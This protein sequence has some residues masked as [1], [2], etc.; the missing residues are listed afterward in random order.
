VSRSL[1]AG[2]AAAA[3]TLAAAAAAVAPAHAITNGN[4][5]DGGH[6][7]VGL[8]VAQDGDG[9]PLWRCSGTLVSGTVFVT[10]GHCT[11]DEQGG[12][13]ENVEVWFGQGP[14]SPSTA[15]REGQGDLLCQDDDGNRYDGYPCSGD[16]SG[17]A[18]TH[19]QYDSNQFW[20]Y[21]LG[22]VVLEEGWELPTGYDYATLPEQGAYDGWKSNRKQSFT[23]VGYGLQKDHGQGA[24]WKDAAVNQRMVSTPQL[25]SVNSPYV[26]DYSMKLSNNA[27]T[28]GTCGGDSGGPNFLSGSL[29]IAGVTSFGMNAQ[30][31]GG[32]GGAYRLDGAD[33]VAFLSTW[34]DDTGT[35]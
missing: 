28:G 32:I 24:S 5:D 25:I 21:D 26:G 6:P 30:T 1:L 19:P 27:R 20:R 7:M 35:D 12:S 2:L 34:V 10:A 33:D 18:H 11:S 4:L 15:F 22:V 17:A 29:E 8:M 14:I 23:A 9:E 3:T 31:C 13:V 16:V